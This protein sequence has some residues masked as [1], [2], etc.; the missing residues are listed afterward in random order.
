MPLAI[1]LINNSTV[2]LF[3]DLQNFDVSKVHV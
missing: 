2:F 1:E 3:V